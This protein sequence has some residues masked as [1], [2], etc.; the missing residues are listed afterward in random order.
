M[1]VHCMK[2]ITYKSKVA[3]RTKHTYCVHV[4]RSLVPMN[5]EVGTKCQ[6]TLKKIKEAEAGA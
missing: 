1:Y 2:E 4:P 5:I 3:F 6:V